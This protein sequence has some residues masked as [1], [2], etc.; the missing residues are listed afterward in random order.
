MDI[1][2][3]FGTKR[4]DQGFFVRSFG[5]TKR[6]D[7]GAQSGQDGKSQGMLSCLARNINLTKKETRTTR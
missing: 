2:R 3:S 1:A 5:G 4:D 7:R 6:D